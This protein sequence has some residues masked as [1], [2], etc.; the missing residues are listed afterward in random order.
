MDHYANA[1]RVEP[2]ICWRMVS[3][4]PGYRMGSPTDCREPVRWSGRA[5]VGKKRMRL[6]SCDGHV[7]GLEDLRAVRSPGGSV[8]SAVP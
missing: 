3:R 8:K 5:M 4:G 6:S 1:V 7:D 2:G